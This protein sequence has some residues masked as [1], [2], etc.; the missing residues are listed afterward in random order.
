LF[1]LPPPAKEEEGEDEKTTKSMSSAQSMVPGT[2]TTVC[3][4]LQSHDIKLKLTN[5]LINTLLLAAALD[6][7]VTPFFDAAHHV[8]FTR[9]GAV[10]PDAVKIQVRNP[11]NETLVIL[12]R[13]TS[14]GSALQWKTGPSVHPKQEFDWVEIVRL[15]NL[16]PSTKYECQSF[17][18][19]T[20]IFCQLN[21]L[22]RHRREAG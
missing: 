7:T 5:I 20:L 10:Y 21:L 14:S 16:W 1:P 17:F 4:S 8:A 12:Y 13:E 19:L 6:L 15:P 3:F 11:A 2:W 18:F 9:V 22:F